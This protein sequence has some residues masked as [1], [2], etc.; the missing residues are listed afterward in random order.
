MYFDSEFAPTP[1]GP[2]SGGRRGRMAVTRPPGQRGGRKEKDRE[3]RRF[4]V[5]T[6]DKNVRRS[7]APTSSGVEIKPHSVPLPL[8]GAQEQCVGSPC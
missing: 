1:K 7:S 3:L 4:V 5:R 6:F 2:P 8:A